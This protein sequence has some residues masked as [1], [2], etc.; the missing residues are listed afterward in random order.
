MSYDLSFDKKNA[1]TLAVL[2][3]VAAILLVAAGY[4]IGV[5]HSEP[6][7]VR[8]LNPSK[9][10]SSPPTQSPSPGNATNPTPPKP[11]SGSPATAGPNQL[12]AL[13]LGAFKSSENAN[14]EVKA[15]KEK[16][17]IANVLPLQDAV[18]HTWYAVRYGSYATT[19]DA[20]Q[21]A[22][23]LRTHTDEVPLIRPAIAF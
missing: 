13:Q 15:L 14:A 12:F 1:V 7:S 19:A 2:C 5:L 9:P 6:S 21:A 3:S 16:G 23:E 18:G 20:A 22:A 17:V 10:S 8:L 11:N 4:L